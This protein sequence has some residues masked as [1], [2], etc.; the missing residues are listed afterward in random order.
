[1][2]LRTR[3]LRARCE[4]DWVLGAEVCWGSPVALVRARSPFSPHSSLAGI[5]RRYRAG[6]LAHHRC[7]RQPVA[8][9]AAHGAA[10][11]LQLVR[12]AP[13]RH[14]RPH[15]GATTRI[16]AVAANSSASI[17]IVVARCIASFEHSG[18]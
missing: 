7:R 17:L 18:A 6:D 3:F 1:M 2:R 13:G 14:S 11:G 5:D 10:G 8:R 4:D 15:A 9:P 16:P 12:L